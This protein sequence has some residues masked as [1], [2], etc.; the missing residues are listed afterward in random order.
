[1]SKRMEITIETERLL[2]IRRSGAKNTRVFCPLCRDDSE[3]LTTDEA[4]L[5]ANTGSRAIFALIEQEQVHFA[6]TERGLLLVCGS[7][8]GKLASSK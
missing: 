6:E 8:L 4:A 5:I 1:M 7:S 3:M 2:V